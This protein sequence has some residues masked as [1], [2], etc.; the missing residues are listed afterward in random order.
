MRKKA[1]LEK[2]LKLRPHQEDFINKYLQQGGR[3]IAYHGLG[4]GKTITSVGAVEK[5]NSKSALVLTPA[6]L[7]KNYSDTI[8]K[9]VTPNS[10]NKYH[11]MS[12][13][14]FRM[15]P[16]KYMDTYKP[17][18][19]V[20]DEFHR[21]KDPKSVSYNAIKAARPRVKH[22]MGLTGTTVQNTPNE[23]F[24]LMNLVS[25]EN[26]KVPSLKEFENKYTEKKKVYPKGFSGLIGRLTGRYG[27]K[28]VLKNEKELKKQIN[29][30]I[31]KNVPTPEFMSHFP[32]QEVKDIDVPMT[33]EQEKKY[34][35][36]MKKDLGFIDRW[37]IKHD[38]PPKAKDSKNFFSKLMHAR[39]V[40]NTP[41]VL[42]NKKMDPIQSSG[43]LTSSYKSLS[44]HLKAH[45][46]NKAMVYSNF[47][48]SGIHPY[49]EALKRDNIPYGVFTG[50]VKRKAKHQDVAD[51]NAGKKRVLLVSPSG[52]EGLDLK[53]TTLQQNIDKS[54][55][56]AANNQVIGRAA[57]YE[58]H[59]ALPPE[60]RKVKVENYYSTIKPG[61][62][63]RL[64]G[65]KNSPSIDQYIAHRAKEKQNLND[66]FDKLF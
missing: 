60:M 26:K 48:E 42:S 55:N 24:P 49:E 56:P 7:Q 32:K 58:S 30:Y 44:Q 46:L 31:H 9:F 66:Q 41:A 8:N 40:S 19:M 57:R 45:P 53:G 6:S 27:E 18:T 3:Q 38:I 14:K 47:T 25:G 37:R 64:F 10:R 29:P 20:V 23:I 59:S 22:F 13:E 63:K 33:H 28:K 65:K 4:S 62:I 61:F 52:K 35:Y 16:N 11:V 34:N 50:K 17:D 12:Y 51:Y 2:T 54:W 43:K 39:E 36:F 21:D 15:N 1:A 5:S